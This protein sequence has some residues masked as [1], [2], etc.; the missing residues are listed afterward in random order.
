[1]ATDSV[2]AKTK[3]MIESIPRATMS[4]PSVTGLVPLYIIPRWGSLTVVRNLDP[5]YEEEVISEK[6]TYKPSLLP[7][8][9][10]P[11]KKLLAV[12]DGWSESQAE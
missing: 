9:K 6:G 7:G 8:F 11:L 12:A 5:G 1:V 2:Y 3:W 10:L 4:P